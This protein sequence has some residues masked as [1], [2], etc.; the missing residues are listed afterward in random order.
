MKCNPGSFFD[1]RCES[2]VYDALF[3]TGLYIGE[4][5]IPTISCF[6]EYTV[7]TNQ[8]YCGMVCVKCLD[9]VVVLKCPIN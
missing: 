9:Y 4:N 2:V 8:Q 1:L 7:L 3:T 6:L 5:V